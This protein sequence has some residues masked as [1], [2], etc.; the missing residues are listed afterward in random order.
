[1]RT[2][3][4]DI[5]AVGD[6]VQVIDFVNKKPTM[7]PL[8]WPA[9][10]QGR[11]VADILS[12][13]DV[14]YKGTLG[15]LVA[16][17]FDLT[18]AATGNNEKTLKEHGIPYEAIHIHPASHAGYYPGATQVSF[19][20]LFN[21]ETGKILGAQGVGEV[22]IDKRI[23][24]IANSI[25]AGFTVYDLQ[26]T[27]VCY[28]PPYNSAKDPVN[29]MGYCGANIMEN[30]VENTQWYEVE[31][32]VK[33]NEY[34]LDVRE[35]YEV[36]NGSIPNVIN[37]P[38][39]QLRDRLNEIPKDRKIYVCCQVGLRGYIACTILNQYGYNT[40]NIDGGYKTYSSI[41]NAE[42]LISDQ[43][44]SLEVIL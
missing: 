11:L 22:G 15:S 33:N 19:K 43:D 2:S 41:K 39:G 28:A 14:E 16:K 26:D 4:E 31:D 38:L 6:A 32:L 1:M 21:P 20:M 13:K 18:V 5:Y 8:A 34:I 40:S 35:E 30:I 12:G 25:K 27:E 29:M 23:D 44:E 7:I 42:K 9:N 24:L 36:A 17:V 3:D 10:R 37:I